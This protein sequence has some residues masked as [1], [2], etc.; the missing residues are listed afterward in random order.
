MLVVSRKVAMLGMWGVGKTSLVRRFVSSIFDETYHST[1]GVKIDKKVVDIADRQVKMVLW[2]IAGAEDERAVPLHYL[3]GAAGYLL[4][5]DGTRRL[6]L[7]IGLDLIASVKAGIGNLPFI[8][9]VNK[10]DLEWE[11]TR[12]EIESAFADFDS[13]PLYTS[14]RTGDNVELAFTRLAEQ[15]MA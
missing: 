12:D 11:M 6:S 13:K 14:A 2:D 10:S 5:V 1:I 15:V 8:P 7:D 4:V 3:G 9:L